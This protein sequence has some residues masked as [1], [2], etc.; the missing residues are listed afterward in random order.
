MRRLT[1]ALAVAALVVAGLA[2]CAPVATIAGCGD[3]ASG[4]A[5][6]IVDATGKVGSEPD[7][8]FP[9]PLISDG[10]EVTELV[11]GDGRQVRPGDYAGIGLSVFLGTDGQSVQTVGYDEFV[12]LRSDAES[13]LSKALSCATVG[14]RFVLTTTP[15]AGFGEGTA[16][17]V[18]LADD[19]TM[20]V[21]IDV[22]TA[23]LGKADGL[24]QL[25]KPGLPSVVTAVDGQPGIVLPGSDAPTVETDFLVKSGAGRLV[26]DGDQVFVEVAQF[27]W[28]DEATVTDST[29]DEG[30]TPKLV[31]AGAG[32][33]DGESQAPAYAKYLEGLKIGSQL[34]VVVPSESGGEAQVY[35]IDLLGIV[36]S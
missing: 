7:V 8:E 14:S 29:W 22:R 17:R 6:S 33:P 35:V 15:D 3:F 34:M 5:S 13:S 26:D 11:H 9:T 12:P 2:A 36:E 10:D 20:V 16:E 23:Y 21:V 31:D 32:D 28:G 25:Q 4:E 1:P 27:G 24:N 19:A 30:N 18:G